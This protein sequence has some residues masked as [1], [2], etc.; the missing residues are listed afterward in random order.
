M[1]VF[2]TPIRKKLKVQWSPLRNST[3][4]RRIKENIDF[5]FSSH[6]KSNK[7]KDNLSKKSA[8]IVN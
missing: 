5:L 3:G 6:F 2:L 1:N 8:V 7:N 4:G